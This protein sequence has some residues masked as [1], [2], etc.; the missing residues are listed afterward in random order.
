MPRSLP[1]L[2]ALRVPQPWHRAEE[3]VSPEPASDKGFDNPMF[4]V[5]S[6]HC[7]GS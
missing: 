1:R 3:P 2:P 5:V 4:N 7:L 6:H